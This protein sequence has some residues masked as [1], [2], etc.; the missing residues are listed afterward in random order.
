MSYSELASPSLQHQLLDKKNCYLM[1]IR[2]EI[3]QRISCSRLIPWERQLQSK[4]VAC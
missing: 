4:L 3:L 2:T 1:E